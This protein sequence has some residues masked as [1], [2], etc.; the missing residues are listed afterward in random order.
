MDQI[1]EVKQKADIV[2]VIGN[3][4]TLT[5]AGRNY[6][7][8]CPFHSEKTPSFMVSQELQLYKCFGCGQGGDVFAFLQNIEGIDFAQALEQLAEKTGVKLERAQYDPEAGRKKLLFE[9][10]H[11]TAEFYHYLLTRHPSGK[12]ALDYLKNK[13]K[14]SGEAVKEFKR[15][16]A[17][18]TWDTVY[19]FL[20]KKKYDPND[21]ADAGVIVRK[22]SGQG[23]ID[24][25]RGRIMF[26]F[27]GMD[28]K[29]VGF[30]GRT[31]LDRD[32]KYL[33]TGETAIFHKSSFIY[34]LNKAK[35]AIKQSGAVFVEG[36]VDVIS[37]YQAGIRNVVATSG[38]A[39]TAMQLKLI[40]RYTEDAIFCFD[41]DTAGAAA[42][43]RA[44]E[45]A[46]KEDLNIKVV[47]VPDKYADLD[48]YI[49]ADPQGAKAAIKNPV[50]VYDFFVADAL[51]KNNKESA[52]GK[53][54]IME[55][56]GQKFSKVTSSV[57][58]DHY[59]K[60]ISKELNLDT[61]T[62]HGILSG[63]SKP[64]ADN[65]SEEKDEIRNEGYTLS[66]RSPQ[67][68]LIALLLKTPLDTAQSILY[69]LAQKDFTNPVLQEIFTE[70]KEYNLGRKRKFDIKYFSNTLSEENQN[71]VNELYLWDVEHITEEPRR[72]E[73]EPET[74]FARI[75]R[76]TAKKELKELTDK[77]K[78]AELEKNTKLVGELSEK[79]KNIS[80]RLL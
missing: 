69:K 22:S 17:H 76:E 38:T 1:S 71:S 6:K 15:G 28:E 72:L 7:G 73:I 24:K 67:E 54:K 66:K 9:I 48:D 46:E 53:K 58:L 55:E 13:R 23:Y 65:L 40:A 60:L 16:Y 62:V 57:L 68:Y 31:V 4:V 32:P 25:Y 37:A 61:E 64:D 44:I 26:P 51:K 56:L 21:M 27:T 41:S 77:I 39:L 50:P 11:L 59:I 34:G 43:Q 5:K 49:K 2:E 10:N 79:F 33:N 70:L 8:L 36:P 80:E 78:Q 63:K 35:V 19:Q 18:E 29:I 3:Y 45:L 52:L 74:A 14:L 20:L 42:I 30:S 47:I 75:K 12:N